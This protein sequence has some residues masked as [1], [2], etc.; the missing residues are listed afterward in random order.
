ML[1]LTLTN[2]ESS[3]VFTSLNVWQVQLGVKVGKQRHQNSN[4]E[5]PIVRLVLK[6]MVHQDGSKE[7]YTIY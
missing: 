1:I 3:V 5:K 6:R 7:H 2:I 4:S